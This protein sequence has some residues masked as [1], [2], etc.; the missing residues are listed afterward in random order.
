MARDYT[1]YTSLPEEECATIYNEL[2]VHYIREELQDF[3]RYLSNR[4]W[5]EDNELHQE[6]GS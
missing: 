3:C 4:C 1:L 5:E 2:R 6:N